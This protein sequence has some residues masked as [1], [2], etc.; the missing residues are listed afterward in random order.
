MFMATWLRVVLHSFRPTISLLCETARYQAT[1]RR[2]HILSSV[3][4]SART[5]MTLTGRDWILVNSFLMR[6][7]PIKVNLSTR[8]VPII[9]MP[10]I[11]MCAGVDFIP[12]DGSKAARRSLGAEEIG[13]VYG[14][15]E[16]YIKGH[17]GIL[18]GYPTPEGMRRLISERMKDDCLRV[19]GG[20]F[21]TFLKINAI[22]STWV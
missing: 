9:S 6:T 11:G 17:D 18:P 8:L 20:M 15:V 13:F 12:A 22:P 2:S 16:Y 14:G 21:S 3:S 19:A 1:R 4:I 5:N 7:H 10:T